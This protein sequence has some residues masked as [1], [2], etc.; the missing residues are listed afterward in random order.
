MHDLTTGLAK[1]EH[2]SLEVEFLVARSRK[3]EHVL[4]IPR[5][6]IEA[7]VLSYME[8]AERYSIN[9]DY[10]GFVVRVPEIAAFVLHKAIVQT[11]RSSEPKRMKD[12]A[13]V[14]SLG[15]V[16]ASR[17][18]I[19]NRMVEIFAGFPR[20]WQRIVLGMVEVH[21]SVLHGLLREI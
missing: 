21:S 20:K 2:R 4:K 6:N 5:L 1:Y 19:R 17:D 18:D 15:E 8:I 11:L 10:R 14:S 16:V 3:I 12:A 13:T 9:V 7:Q